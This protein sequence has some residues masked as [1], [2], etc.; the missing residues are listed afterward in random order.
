MGSKF[1]VL[2]TLRVGLF[3]RKEYLYFLLL[4]LFFFFLCV[5]NSE[6]Y[7]GFML[8]NIKITEKTLIFSH[9]IWCT[10]GH[11][12]FCWAPH[13][14]FAN[15]HPC[16]FAAR[17]VSPK[18]IFLT[19]LVTSAVKV[20]VLMLELFLARDSHRRQPRCVGRGGLATSTT[21][22]TEIRAPHQHAHIIR[23][24]LNR[25]GYL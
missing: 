25:R 19:R 8:Y 16:R 23:L 9:R 21:G 17:R 3:A 1:S 18:S 12:L 6:I 24:I 22:R 7:R 10:R 11:F 14:T 5:H 20:R 13:R 4:L 2:S 15:F